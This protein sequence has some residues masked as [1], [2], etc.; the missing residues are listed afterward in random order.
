MLQTQLSI[1]SAKTEK[2]KSEFPLRLSVN[3]N[4]TISLAPNS[5]E[6]TQIDVAPS[7]SKSLNKKNEFEANETSDTDTAFEFN[8]LKTATQKMTLKGTKIIV[9][10]RCVFAQKKTFKK[11]NKS[12][13]IKCHREIKK[14]LHFKSN[15]STK[16][17][18]NNDFK[19]NH[20]QV[21]K[22]NRS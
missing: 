9:T 6:Y 10:R 15:D 8:H 21:E 16:I 13:K 22:F 1:N 19:K 7:T 4:I 20:D 17:E 18:K 3:K 11:K 2:K 14:D 5:V 12:S